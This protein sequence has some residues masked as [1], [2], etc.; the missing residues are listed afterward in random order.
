MNH[1]QLHGFFD[2]LEK[3]AAT[4]DEYAS[5]WEERLRRPD[6]AGYHK[7]PVPQRIKLLKRFRSEIERRVGPLIEKQAGIVE[8]LLHSLKNT[9]GGLTYLGREKALSEGARRH[10][11]TMRAVEG[12]NPY[13][14]GWV[15][16]GMRPAPRS[17]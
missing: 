12:P 10:K 15:A 3:I 9:G 5:A 11:E 1:A 16:L 7:L 6:A 17:G 8:T 2:E 13:P 4:P 14:A